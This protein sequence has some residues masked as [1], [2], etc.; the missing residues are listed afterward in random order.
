[1]EVGELGVGHRSF[2]PYLATHL[3]GHPG[4][5][6]EALGHPPF[7]PPTAVTKAMK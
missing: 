1:M 6:T 3:P 5:V 4:Q 7:A 2:T